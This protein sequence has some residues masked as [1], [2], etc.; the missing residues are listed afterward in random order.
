MHDTTLK[1]YWKERKAHLERSRADGRVLIRCEA[2][3]LQVSCPYHAEWKRMA[4]DLGGRWRYKTG[5]WS[6]PWSNRRSVLDALR[7]VYGKQAL[8]KWGDFHE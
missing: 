8:G 5:F 4:V 7:L 3:R 1:D 2:Q 6:F